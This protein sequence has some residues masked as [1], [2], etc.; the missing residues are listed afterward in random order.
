MKKGKCM[1]QI[2]VVGNRKKSII[3][4]VFL[5]SLNINFMNKH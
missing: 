4:S 3:G 2:M 5:F 1:N